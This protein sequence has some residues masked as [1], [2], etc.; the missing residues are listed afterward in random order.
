ML[1]GTS[2][3]LQG[4]CSV[5]SVY[6]YSSFFVSVVFNINADKA[7]IAI[8]VYIV[9]NISIATSDPFA[10]SLGWS[11]SRLRWHLYWGIGQGPKWEGGKVP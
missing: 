6:A 4:P 5:L 10:T 9:G 2:A 11:S 7:R 8:R 1:T 3:S